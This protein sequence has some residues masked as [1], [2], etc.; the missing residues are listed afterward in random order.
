M[1]EH[2]D[3]IGQYLQDSDLELW[4]CGT[5]YRFVSEQVSKFCGAKVSPRRLSRMAKRLGLRW[6]GKSKKMPDNQQDLTSVEW[7]KLI[8]L[9][10]SGTINIDRRRETPESLCRKLREHDHKVTVQVAKAIL[11]QIIGR[12]NEYQFDPPPDLKNQLSLCFPSSQEQGS[13]NDRRSPR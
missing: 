4:G 11:N 13:S 12:T 2:A 6:N 3:Q 8:S 5:S 7:G 1:A 10:G 9:V